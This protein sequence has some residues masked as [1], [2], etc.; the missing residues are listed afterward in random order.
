MADGFAAEGAVAAGSLPR[1]FSPSPLAGTGDPRH[2]ALRRDAIGAAGIP[3][4]SGGG[5]LALGG[6][7]AI[8]GKPP[9]PAHRRRDGRP[10]GAP[11]R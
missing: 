4:L 2:G 9:R 7:V 1:V 5:R 3:A 8:P 11:S 6:T 10:R